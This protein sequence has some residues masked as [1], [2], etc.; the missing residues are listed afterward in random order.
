M[1]VIKRFDFTPILGWSS[2]RHEKFQI[3]KRQYYYNYYAKYDPRRR[4]EY[5]KNMT[6]IPM[7]TGSIIHDVIKVLLKRLQKTVKEIDTVRFFDYAQRKTKEHC[8]AKIF[9][10]IH[11][12]EIGRVDMDEVFDK[13]RT[14]LNNLLKSERFE[15]L[16]NKVA[17]NRNDWIIEPAGYGETRI[18]GMKAYC[19]VDCL[20][21]VENSFFIVDWK[22][23]RPN[24][25]HRKQ[26]L[27]YASWASFHFEKD[28]VKINPIIAYL[29][30][31]YEEV[32]IS[33]NGFDI[34]EFSSWVKMETAEMY[35]FCNDIEENIPKDKAIFT[36]TPNE[37]LCNYCNFRELCE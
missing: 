23:G 13:V 3:C 25:K 7:E 26:L 35:E 17:H 28:P 19:K 14:S 6:S 24:N 15:W 16:T 18:G 10:E 12:G 1:K 31:E 37:T 2:S 36:E 30:P 20:F 4:I 9:S 22:T 34:Q 21:P 27:G 5:L 11:Y 8:D 32:Q 33:V 29:Y